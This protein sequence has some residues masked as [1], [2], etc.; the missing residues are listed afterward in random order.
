MAGIISP[1]QSK[2]GKLHP[3]VEAM[4]S[5][6]SVESMEPGET[7]YSI[8]GAIHVDGSSTVLVDKKIVDR[9]RAPTPST[10]LKS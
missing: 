3:V 6:S 4:V 2:V 8:T 5:S 9:G 7:T 10:I 1:F